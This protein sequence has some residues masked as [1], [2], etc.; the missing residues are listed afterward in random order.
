MRDEGLGKGLDVKH[1]MRRSGMICTAST[2]WRTPTDSGKGRTECPKVPESFQKLAQVM[3]HES[4]ANCQELSR[5]PSD[6]LSEDAAVQ[7]LKAHY[8][9]QRGGKSRAW[10][11]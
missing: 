8:R 10:G 7:S 2:S 9:K 5:R 4:H 1:V 11:V 3:W 6:D